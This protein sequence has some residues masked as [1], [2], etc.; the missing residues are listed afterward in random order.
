MKRLASMTTEGQK[1]RY[2]NDIYTYWNTLAY[3]YVWFPSLKMSL[4]SKVTFLS[5]PHWE[6]K[7]I[8]QNPFISNLFWKP[9]NCLSHRPTSPHWPK[10]FLSKLK[11]Y[12]VSL[13]KQLEKVAKQQIRLGTFALFVQWCNSFQ[14]KVAWLPRLTSKPQKS[15][16]FSR[17]WNPS[18]VFL[19]PFFSFLRRKSIHFMHYIFKK[20]LWSMYI[21]E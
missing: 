14:Q 19:R 10:C 15:R 12:K 9:W 3:Q 8:R 4:H 20:L 11:A 13:E 7:K 16:S 21:N 2:D 18:G 6:C 17:T 1:I 5:L